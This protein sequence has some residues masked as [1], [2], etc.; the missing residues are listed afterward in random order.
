MSESKYQATPSDGKEILHILESSAAKG[1]IELIYTRRPDA[2]E[3]YIK[4]AKDTR[5]FISRDG[6]KAIGTCAELIREVYIGGEACRSAYICGLKKDADYEGSVGFG[7]RFIKDLQQNDIDF[8]YCSVVAENT[9]ARRMFEKS[10]RLLSMRSISGY[11]TYIINPKVRIKAPKHTFTFRRATESDTST[12][13]NFLNTEGK[14]KDMFPVV[15]SL[16]DFYNLHI[17][18]FYLLLDG[19]NIIATAALWRQTEYKQY[20]VK[21]YGGAMKLARVF[22]PIL[23]ALRYIKL[24]QENEP[25]DFPMLAFFLCKDDN[26]DNYRIFLNEI[27]QEI[28]KS[29]GMFVI[30]LHD[31]HYA[32]PIIDKLPSVNFKTEIYEIKFPWSEQKYKAPDPQSV[33]LECGL[34]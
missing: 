12:L 17:R 4:D 9:D 3:S 14:R 34:L 27:K 1:S 7:A 2:Y 20:I 30:G 8:Y 33:Y 21:R 28:S 31:S 23:S 16:D 25:L 29:Y 5:V 19:E 6:E 13:L 24:P 18:D 11:K 15:K 26:A 22:N 10:R 32:R